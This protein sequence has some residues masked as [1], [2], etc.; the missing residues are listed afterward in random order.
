MKKSVLVYAYGRTIVVHRAGLC[1]WRYSLD[2]KPSG[3]S[4]LTKELARRAAVRMAHERRHEAP[5]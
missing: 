3:G 2:G 1:C 4:H 5:L